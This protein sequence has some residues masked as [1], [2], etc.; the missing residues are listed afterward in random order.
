MGRPRRKETTSPDE[1]TL[2]VWEDMRSEILHELQD[3]G[4]VPDSLMDIMGILATTLD[5]WRAA[6]KSS[7]LQLSGV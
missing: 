6:L 3:G 7:K 4:D 1:L 5:S 2:Q